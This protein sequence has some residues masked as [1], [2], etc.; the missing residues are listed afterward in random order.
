MSGYWTKPTPFETVLASSVYEDIYILSSDDRLI[1]YEYREGRA[2]KNLADVDK[3]FFQELFKY[4]KIKQAR[5]AFGPS[6]PGRCV[7]FAA[8]D[9]EICTCRTRDCLE[10]RQKGYHTR[11]STGLL[12]GRLHKTGMVLS[13]LRE[14]RPTQV[15]L[16][17]NIKYLQMRSR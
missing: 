6:S 3:A 14:M 11:I 7:K 16:R 8:K 12:A 13:L 2:P 10:S 1:A 4:F 5:N 9:D 17:E 15:H